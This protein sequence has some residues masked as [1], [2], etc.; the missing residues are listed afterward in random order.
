MVSLCNMHYSAIYND[1]FRPCKWAIIRLLVEPMGRLYTK[2]FGGGDEISSY[3]ILWGSKL[4]IL[5]MISGY[6]VES[7]DIY[8]DL[9]FTL[10]KNS[11]YIK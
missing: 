6:H 7:I 10:T 1:M 8:L 3:I 9:A 11:Y 2:G 5:H 4:L